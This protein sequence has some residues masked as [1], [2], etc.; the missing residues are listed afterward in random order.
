[1][2]T[3]GTHEDVGHQITLD[4]S[5]INYA[6]QVFPAGSTLRGNIHDFGGGPVLLDQSY[7]TS[8]GSGLGS[9]PEQF[10]EDGS[11]T[12]LRAA[13][14]SYLL[15]SSGFRNLTRFQSAEFSITG[16]NLFLWTDVVGIDP[17]TN[18]SGSIYAR[19]YDY[20]NGPGTRSFLFSIK[21]NY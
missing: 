8:L 5:L 2:Y 12:R 19:G 3:F 1:M 15:N 14:L 11:W 13:S 20:F 10:I 21:L 9:A 16:R 7:Y 6:G 4:Q 18:Y 17:D